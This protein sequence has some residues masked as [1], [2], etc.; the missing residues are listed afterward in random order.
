MNGCPVTGGPGD[1]PVDPPTPAP[2]GFPTAAGDLPFCYYCL[3]SYT[4]S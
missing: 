4:A 3:Q 2:P 1:P